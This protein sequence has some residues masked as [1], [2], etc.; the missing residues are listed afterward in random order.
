VPP[1]VR[2][3]NR[4]AAAELGTAVHRVLAAWIKSGY[5]SEAIDDAAAWSVGVE[6]D[7]IARLANW[8][9]RAWKEVAASFPEPMTEAHLEV[10][11]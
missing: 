5:N 10:Q 8:A 7:E 11:E 9:W 4:N 6:R 1:A 2:L 3:D